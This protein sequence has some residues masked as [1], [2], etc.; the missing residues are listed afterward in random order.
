MGAR[1]IIAVAVDDMSM[2]AI[3]V[4]CILDGSGIAAG[5]IQSI[6][7]YNNVAIARFLLAVGISCLVVYYSISILVL[8][9][10]L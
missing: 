10:S 6:F 3:L 2:E 5:F 4:C 7:P 9:M 1:M 8:R